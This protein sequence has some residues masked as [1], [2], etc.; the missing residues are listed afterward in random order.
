M[1]QARGFSI[2]K[3]GRSPKEN[4][5]A[6]EIDVE[7]GAAA[8]ADGASD[9]SFSKA[10]AKL[11]VDSLKLW[12]LEASADPA[13]LVAWLE[14][15]QGMW[16]RLVAARPLPWHAQHKV[17]QG[18]FAAV[19]AAAVRVDGDAVQWSALAVGDCCLFLV[20][21]DRLAAAFPLDDPAAFGTSPYLVGTSPDAN[22]AIADHLKR[23]SGEAKRG[24][25]LILASDAVAQWFLTAA[26]A[27]ERP[28]ATLGDVADVAAFQALIDRLREAKAIRN[29]DS[30]IVFW[31]T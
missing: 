25:R 4:E 2:P 5:D 23:A 3:A 10:W 20:D 6:F 14:R 8:V 15:P 28:W 24:A 22:R 12:P 7:R 19:V 31:E 18:A 29:D 21:G 27:G 9:S 30:T 26:R 16:R 11:L 13:T 1:T 17:Q